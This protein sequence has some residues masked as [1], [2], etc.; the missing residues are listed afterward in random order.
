MNKENGLKKKFQKELLS[1]ISSLVLLSVLGRSDKAMYGYQI[2]KMLEAEERES[3]LKQGAL[4]PVL[5]SLE[6]NNLLESNVEPS[7]SGP[8]PGHLLFRENR[9]PGHLHPQK[10]FNNPSFQYSQSFDRYRE[11]TGDKKTENEEGRNKRKRKSRK[12]PCE[13][14]YSGYQCY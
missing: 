12:H 2:A 13:I 10:P 8:P 14:E 9:P 7:I 5:R 4:Y 1:G 6:K 3:P 11:E